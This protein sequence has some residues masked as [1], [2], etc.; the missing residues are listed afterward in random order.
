MSQSEPTQTGS[1]IGES[2]QQAELAT[3]QALESGEIC[4]SEH[5]ISSITTAFL[6]G[7]VLGGVVAWTIAEARHHT[8]R[9]ACKDLA[10]DWLQRLH[11]D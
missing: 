8:Y 1:P 2:V 6:G 10:R 5:P 11:L 3:A 7:L 9:E 4:V